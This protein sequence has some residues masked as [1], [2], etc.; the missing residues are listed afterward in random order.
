MNAKNRLIQKLLK[1]AKK[2]KIL[3]YPVLAL[4]ALISIFSY[5]FD[6]STGAGKR[7][8]AVVMVMVMLVSQSY[9]L[10]SSATEVED[11]VNANTVE[12]ENTTEKDNIDEDTT[13]TVTE[14]KE[15]DGEG[16]SGLQDKQ[17]ESSEITEDGE[18]GDMST[19]TELDTAATGD[20]A[21]NSEDNFPDGN[22]ISLPSN[23]L[24]RAT[25]VTKDAALYVEEDNG[26]TKMFQSCKVTQNEDGLTYDLSSLKTY[27][28]NLSSK[29]NDYYEYEGW[30]KTYENG[31]FKD[32]IEEREWTSFTPANGNGIALFAKR[33]LKKY[34]ITINTRKCN[35]L[36]ASLDGEAKLSPSVETD[37]NQCIY[38]IDVPASTVEEVTSASFTISNLKKVGYAL[39]SVTGTDADTKVSFS[40]D[41]NAYTVTVDL[42]GRKSDHAFNLIWEGQQ[43]DIKYATSQ[44]TG[45]STYTQTGVTFDDPNAQ[46]W[47]GKSGGS[48]VEEP[49]GWRF[50]GWALEGHDI[51]N[52]Y[53]FAAEDGELQKYLYSNPTTILTPEYKYIG[54]EVKE[55]ELVYRYNTPAAPVT[56]V[57]VYSDSGETGDFTYEI[58]DDNKSELEKIGIKAEIAPDNKGITISQT[59]DLTANNINVNKTGVVLKYKITDK[60]KK[61]EDDLEEQEY[62]G[63]LTIKLLPGLVSLKENDNAFTKVYDG[64]N[65][66]R[67]EGNELE[68][69]DKDIVVKFDRCY[70][71]DENVGDKNNGYS[72]NIILVN[73]EVEIKNHDKE[74]KYT[75]EGIEEEIG[76]IKGKITPRPVFVKTTAKYLYNREFV[77]A[78]EDQNPEL[79]L[80]LDEGRNN[81]T[82]GF[83]DGDLQEAG[84]SEANAAINSLYEAV[85]ETDRDDWGML[86]HSQK[87]VTYKVIRKAREEAKLPLSN[88]DFILN[89]DSSASYEVRLEDPSERVNYNI[90]T[91]GGF[92]E[93]K[94]Y[95]DNEVEIVPDRTS[96]YDK[97]RTSRYDKGEDKLVLTQDNTKP[98]EDGGTITFQLTDSMHGGF[99]S[100][101]TINVNVDA[102]IPEYEKYEVEE[103]GAITNPGEGFYFPSE[104]GS[105]SFGHYYNRTITIKVYYSDE[106]SGLNKLYYQLSGNLGS[107]GDTYQEAPFVKDGASGLYVATL[108]V[109]K[110]PE[111]G[112]DKLGTITFYAE[113]NAGNASDHMTLDK[114][115]SEWAVEQTGPAVS[116]ISVTSV[117][118]GITGVPV[119]NKDGEYH[120]QCTATVTV[121]DR[122]SGISGINWKING[123]VYSQKV[124]DTKHDSYTFSIGKGTDYDYFSENGEYKVSAVAW[125]NAKNFSVEKTFTFKVDNDKPIIELYEGQNFNQYAEKVKVRFRTWDEVSGLGNGAT[126][127]VYGPSDSRIDV[128]EEY[129]EEKDGYR[130]YSYYFETDV[131][132]TYRIVVTDKA[133]NQ[134]EQIVDINNVS[135]EKPDCPKVVLNPEPNEKGWITAPDA[136]VNIT[137]VYETAIDKTGVY[138]YYE[139]VTGDHTV[140]MDIPDHMS[141]WDIQLSEGIHD[142]HVWSESYTGVKCDY[143]DDEDNGSH[144]YS[145]KVDSTPPD[146]E[147]KV[148]EGSGNHLLIAFTVKDSIS[149]VDK[150]SIKVLHGSEIVPITFTSAEND[151]CYEGTFEITEKGNYT[152][153]ASDLA[154]NEIEA[155]SFSPMSMKVN[156]IENISE[157]SVTVGAKII[158]G[159]YDISNAAIA[160]RKLT[161][162]QY[163]QS[164]AL[165]LLDSVTGNMTIST[166]LDDLDAGTEY[167]YRINAASSG[168]EVLEYEG[169]FRTLSSDDYG[170]TITGTARYDVLVD[171]EKQKEITVGLFKGKECIRAVKVDPTTDSSFTFMNVLDGS[172]ILTATDGIY[173]RTVR[174]VI[175]EGKVIYPDEQTIDLVLSPMSTSVDVQTVDT[176]DVSAEFNYL[177][178][179]MDDDDR[180]LIDAGGTVEYKLTAKLVRVTSIETAA[181]SAM[182]TAAGTDKI[183]GAYLDLNLYKIV[184]DE[185]GNVFTKKV[186]KLGGG[187]NVSVTIPL[188]NLAGKQGLTVV[189]IHQNGDSYTG[190]QLVDMDSNPSTYTVVTTQFS[191]YAVLYD[192]PQED[193]SDSDVQTNTPNVSQRGEDV[194]NSNNQ[195]SLD[196]NADA[197]KIS[198][199]TTTA[200]AENTSSSVGSLKNYSSAKTGDEAPVA[201]VGVIFIMAMG[202]LVILR[203]KTR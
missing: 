195:Q 42:S 127:E 36:E 187:A 149:H 11:A 193:N 199:K 23:S 179:M 117:V 74:G 176:P 177:E 66:C 1:V 85:E 60:T 19:E 133:G 138:T 37:A 8:V 171:L 101:K 104:G 123:Q 191:T 134:A 78:G 59:E 170:I 83:V 105:V 186:S 90:K 77:R 95:K 28:D 146:V 135:S 148:Q 116:D 33:I 65:S 192:K 18:P 97:I 89:D 88:Y 12:A 52:G 54:I 164:E 32:K 142:L 166:V 151:E 72:K 55:K 86:D 2:H 81:A 24:D 40:G 182:Y 38:T 202:G 124:T 47:D 106:L 112:H 153:H 107:K 131:K 188:G 160:Y 122:T 31:E 26:T 96:G 126:V 68:T 61:K 196:K 144:Y 130:E 194:I 111:K 178:Y 67:I 198:A 129:Q 4:V 13:Q 173:S 94:W 120:S 27:A 22:A 143:A 121:D 35:M 57:G 167:V 115:S 139:M 169:Y 174:V 158:K 71:E 25:A 147:Y 29:N 183:V 84:F 175:K 140:K 119:T 203:R 91:D 17:P 64:N 168:G 49:G 3:T 154:G 41:E 92:D 14:Q 157:N 93:D 102:T 181:L 48:S 99:T 51:D 159:T 190:Q 69:N 185:E 114:D 73:P 7:V 82:N 56:I 39:T 10:T 43:Y 161:D 141:S 21:Q 108:E 53:I 109:I 34:K 165:P 136:K 79:K 137:N 63:E 197:V 70:F 5:F 45:A 125:D 87:S 20:P 150:D 162:E 184:T 75:V 113:D 16:D 62:E 152:I 128:R 50:S 6:W 189:R 9:F 163:I 110:L 98:D 80:E 155:E 46:F 145:L 156:A 118:R 30:Y 15:N 58:L 200:K 132:G 44:E 172:Y 76:K 103:S 180:D 100:F 201:A